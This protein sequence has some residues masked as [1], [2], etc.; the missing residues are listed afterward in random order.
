M[1]ICRDIFQR[2]HHIHVSVCIEYRKKIYLNRYYLLPPDG[3]QEGQNLQPNI[4]MFV[5]KD[6]NIQNMK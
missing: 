3:L 6:D 1:N 5:F 2:Y 4:E